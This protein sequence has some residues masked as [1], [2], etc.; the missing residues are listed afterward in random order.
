M[1]SSKSTLNSEVANP[2]PALMP[3]VATMVLE[4]WQW[5]PRR[6][7]S[8]ELELL[9]RFFLRTHVRANKQG[10]VVVC[11]FALAR[12]PASGSHPHPDEG[13]EQPNEPLAAVGLRQ[14]CKKNEI[15]D[16]ALVPE[17]LEGNE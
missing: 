14:V 9:R 1:R 5:P 12:S 4:F 17:L 8:V 3:L 13:G 7:P 11:P 6:S 10:F 2:E 15:N 16:L